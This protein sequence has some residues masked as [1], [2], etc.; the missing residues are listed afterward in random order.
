MRMHKKARLVRKVLN[1]AKA[2]A[3]HNYGLNPDK[4]YIGFFFHF[5][6]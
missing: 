6:T 2:A 5:I 4:L 1:A 3:D